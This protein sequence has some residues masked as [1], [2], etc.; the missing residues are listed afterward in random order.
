[1]P[2]STIPPS[3]EIG[4]KGRNFTALILQVNLPDIPIPRRQHGRGGRPSLTYLLLIGYENFVFETDGMGMWDPFI[5]WGVHGWRG[6]LGF[7]GAGG[8]VSDACLRQ[9]PRGEGSDVLYSGLRIE[10]CEK[11]W[12]ELGGRV[13]TARWWMLAAPSLLRSSIAFCGFRTIWLSHS[14]GVFRA[15]RLLMPW[16]ASLR[17]EDWLRLR[18]ERLKWSV[19]LSWFFCN[20]ECHAPSSG[21][22]G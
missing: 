18:Q 19:G 14:V 1:M 6:E 11:A 13:D 17:F 21:E 7:A 8:G 10:R 4:C 2:S 22:A 3:T 20:W 16:Y 15:S 12:R 9:R 5:S